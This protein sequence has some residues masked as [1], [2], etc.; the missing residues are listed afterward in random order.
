MARERGRVRGGGTGMDGGGGGRTQALTD[1]PSEASKGMLSLKI[2][3]F[4][5][6]LF[7]QRDSGDRQREKGSV[8]EFQK[9]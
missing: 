1:L 4:S 3:L 6:P 9:L 8:A 5:P 7:P 2:F